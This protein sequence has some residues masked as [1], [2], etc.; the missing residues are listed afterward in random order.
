MRAEAS[1]GGMIVAVA[2]WYII[3]DTLLQEAHDMQLNLVEVS[4]PTSNTEER[5][6]CLCN[7]TRRVISGV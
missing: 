4:K 6:V 7:M 2:A 3:K 1:Q 5:R